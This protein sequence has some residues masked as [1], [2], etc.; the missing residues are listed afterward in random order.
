MKTEKW[1][2]T[3]REYQPHFNCEHLLDALKSLF[4]KYPGIEFDGE[5]YNHDY[6]DDFNG[7]T[8]IIRKQKATP[9][10]KLRAKEVIQYHVYDL[11]S[12]APFGERTEKL[13]EL[14]RGLGHPQIIY[15]PTKKVVNP[16]ELDAAEVES[17][18]L[19]YEGQMVRFNEPY[20]YDSRPWALM[21]RK[22]FVTEEFP[23]LRIEEG[24]GNWSGVAKRVVLQMPNGQ[25][26]GA[27]M[28]GTQEFAAELLAQCRAGKTP[29]EGTTRHFGFTPDGMLR[30][31]VVTDFHQNGRVD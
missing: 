4:G 19:G 22:R 16:D 23:I 31:P 10:Q 7:L 27:G 13:A 14:V 2:A 8:S 6:R 11:P 20:A 21:K 15:V 17:V 28:R 26:C 24:E 25:E 9:E 3:S 29:M 5:L 12:A 1:G 30:F 18:E